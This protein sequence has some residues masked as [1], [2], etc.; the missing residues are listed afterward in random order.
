MTTNAWSD[1]VV[2][3]LRVTYGVE[4]GLEFKKIFIV[5]VQQMYTTK[6]DRTVVVESVIIC[7][8]HGF[9]C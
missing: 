1:L 5:I 7:S 9:D 6:N 3:C 8:N 2:L 4:F